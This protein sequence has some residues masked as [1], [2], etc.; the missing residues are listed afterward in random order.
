MKLHVLRSSSLLLAGL[1]FSACGRGPANTPLSPSSGDNPWKGTGIARIAPKPGPDGG[2]QIMAAGDVQNGPIEIHE[3]RVRQGTPGSQVDI[4][5]NAL[6]GTVLRVPSG[7]EIELWVT[8]SSSST[9]ATPPRLVIDF[10]DGWV[11]N[12][13]CGSCLL[14]HAYNRDGRYTV[15]VLMDDRVSGTTT[16]TFVLDVASA[17]CG[18]S[19]ATNFDAFALFTPGSLLAIPGVSFP[20]STLIDGAFS[21]NTSGNTLIA[22]IGDGDIDITFTDPQAAVQV[23]YAYQSGFPG[24]LTVYEG[25]GPR[26]SPLVGVFDGS[27]SDIGH[28]SLN[29]TSGISR[30]VLSN[31]S[32]GI[33]IDNLG[34]TGACLF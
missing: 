26:V 8:W 22:F 23:D 4:H 3:V 18:T 13:S 24:T 1:F 14:H 10:G 31:G 17:R 32:N 21:S 5:P 27:I 19:V 34:T 20:A 33:L 30:V 25:T 28:I 11:D 29:S 12:I 15:K 16:R 9:L 6:A 7:Q 2:V